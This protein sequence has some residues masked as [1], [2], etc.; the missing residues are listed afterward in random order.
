MDYDG[1]KC[2]NCQSEDI[3]GDHIDPDGYD[4]AYRNCS[5]DCCGALWVEILKVVG[6]DN[7]EVPQKEE[8]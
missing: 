8:T 5:C 1:S 4:S 7:L 3:N 6:Y 2:P